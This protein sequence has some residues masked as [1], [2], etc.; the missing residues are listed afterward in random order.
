MT[1]DALALLSAIRLDQNDDLVRLAYADYL[2]GLDTV[3]F[4]CPTCSP[5]AADPCPRCNGKKTVRV[6]NVSEEREQKIVGY[7]ATG[8]MPP[9][10]IAE[11]PECCGAGTFPPGHHPQRDPA[12]GRDEGGWTNCQT[13]NGAGPSTPGYVLDTSNRDRAELI[14]VQIELAKISPK[15]RELFVMDGAGKR[16]EGLGI[17]LIPRGGGYYSASNAERGLSIET[18]SPNER[19]DV[20]AHLARNDRVGWIRGLKY[21]KHV[22][23]RNEIIFRKDSESG[24]WAGTTLVAREQELLRANETRW[25]RGPVCEEC[26]GKGHWFEKDPIPY[27]ERSKVVCKDCFGT[28]DAGGLM[29]RAPKPITGAEGGAN[30]RV[31][32]VR[33]MKRI[34][35][36]A[37][38]VWE[39]V[40]VFPASDAPEVW[41]PTPWA[42]AACRYHPDVVELW[43]SDA[44]IGVHDTTAD[45][46]PYHV[47]ETRLP[48]PLHNEFR[49]TRFPT[50]ETAR[51]ALARAAVLWVHTF[52]KGDS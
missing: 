27:A 11:C 5:Y 30:H 51:V 34:H 24:P 3:H 26:A 7:D 14:R 33:G 22:E 4:P 25:R 8:G 40:R 46:E 12:S 10:A 50:E 37:T 21:V 42:L 39:R 35:C 16:L 9:I 29:V 41:R 13:C 23:D 36:R 28:G 38:D 19:V 45:S 44:P 32:Y 17:A 6:P 31:E 1:S 18:F 47:Y 15:P 43:L 20:Y 48:E 52:V 49:E 2:D